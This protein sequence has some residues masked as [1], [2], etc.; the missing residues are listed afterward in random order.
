MSEIMSQEL[1]PEAKLKIS[2]GNGAVRLE[3]SYDGKQAD[4]GAYIE[5]QP[6]LLV[7]ALAELVPGDSQAEQLVKNL[8]K[9]VLAAALA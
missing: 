3:L 6:G 7:D 1:G 8:L 2:K 5:I 9:S 4:G